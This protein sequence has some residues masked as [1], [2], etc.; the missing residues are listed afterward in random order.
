[1]PYHRSPDHR[2][3][4]PYHFF[5]LSSVPPHHLKTLSPHDLS[6]YNASHHKVTQLL[7]RIC[8][9]TYAIYT[10]IHAHRY[11]FMSMLCIPNRFFGFVRNYCSLA[12]TLNCFTCAQICHLVFTLFLENQ[13]CPLYF[14]LETQK[15]RVAYGWP[16]SGPR[17]AHGWPMGG[18]WVAHE[19]PMG[20]PL[21][22]DGFCRRSWV[23][24]EWPTGG[25]WVAN[26]WPMGGLAWACSHFLHLVKYS[27]LTL[28]VLC[29]PCCTS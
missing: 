4:L 1:M 27:S 11:T 20:G 10:S 8:K 28:V 12:F 29:L 3:T 5:T 18:P 6:A 7:M 21:V 2:V 22:A 17:V 26:G 19:W 25:P 13:Q 23:A 14:P 24:H 16:M 15:T 9:S